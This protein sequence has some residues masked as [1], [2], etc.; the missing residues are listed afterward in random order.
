MPPHD[1]SQ[2]VQRSKVYIGALLAWLGWVPRPEA[3][4]VTSTCSAMLWEL[5]RT[6]LEIQAAI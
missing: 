1:G 3:K 5:G 2:H 4:Q 6:T